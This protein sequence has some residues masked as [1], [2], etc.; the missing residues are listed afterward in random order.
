M[1]FDWDEAKRK[2]NLRQRQVDFAVAAQIFKGPILSA[3]DE[4]HD[5]GER[6]LRAI[7]QFEGQT[8]VVVYT[9]R[10]EVCHIITA[11]K[12]GKA[13]E[14]RYKAILSRRSYPDA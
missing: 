1:Q 13:G 8:Y 2:E 3:E 7:G 14:R 10:D 6:R 9:L 11:W 4:R 5:Y 12:V